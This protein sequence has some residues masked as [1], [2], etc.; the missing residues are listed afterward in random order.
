MYKVTKEL[1]NIHWQPAYTADTARKQKNTIFDIEADQAKKTNI[2]YI[3]IANLIELTI[4]SPNH[5]A[6]QLLMSVTNLFYNY[7][8]LFSF[9][10]TNHYVK[11]LLMQMWCKKIITK[12]YTGKSQS[13]ALMGGAFMSQ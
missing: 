11:S 7:V 12:I 13:Q 4:F 5:P 10:G 8:C 9:T 1:A 2:Q 3:Y 6:G